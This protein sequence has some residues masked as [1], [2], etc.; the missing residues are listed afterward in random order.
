GVITSTANGQPG[1]GLDIRIR[2]FGSINATQEPLYVVDGVPY[3]GGTS[4]INPDDV[5]SISILKDASATALYG[6]RAANGVVMIT[7]KRG[8]KG[9]NN[10]SLKVTQGFAT[11]GL[12]EYELVDAFEYYP[13]TWEGY[14][15]QLVYPASGTGISRDSA[16]RVASGLTNRTSVAG[17]LAYNP[18]NVPA[19]QIVGVDGKINSNAQLIYGDDLDWTKDL[20]RTGDRKDYVVSFN[21]GADKMDYFLSAGY[22]KEDGYTINSDFERFTARLNVNVQPKEWLR[23][24]L[25][26]S[27]NHTTSNTANDDGSTSFVNPFFFSRNIGPIY[28]VY[29]HNMTTGEYLI[30]PAT[31]QRFWDLGNFGNSGLGIPNRP[32]NGF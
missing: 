9:R 6:S 17:L 14:R 10:V 19:N 11:R 21:G 20:M 24:G 8:K 29:A 25:N 18:F 7:T 15:N 31:G 1:S 2:G 16:A 13:I 4:N 27:A 26:I 32:G 5:E 28:P 12:P 22:L 30:D 3:V 23:T